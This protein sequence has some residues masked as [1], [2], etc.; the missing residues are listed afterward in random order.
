MGRSG[1]RRTHLPSSASRRADTIVTAP[2]RRVP[3]QML[4]HLTTF[5]AVAE[6][7]NF[8]QAARALARSQPAVTAQI[9]QLE[10]ELGTKLFH[11]STRN[12]RLTP[13]G[14]T[15]LVRARKLLADAAGVVDEVRAEQG[16]GGRRIAVSFSPT[17]AVSLV[18]DILA[19]VSCEMPRLRLLLREDLGAEMFAAVQTGAVDFGIG[20]Y[21][22]VP[23]GLDFRPILEQEL[24]LIFKDTHPIARNAAPRVRDLEALDILCS[25]RGSSAR[26]VL[27]RAAMA[28]GFVVRPRY[29][30]LQYPTLFS[31]AS[32]G[33]GV[34]VMPKVDSRILEALSL[35][36]RPLSDRR[37]RRTIGVISR[38]EERLS[39]DADA[40]I[41]TLLR[42]AGE[43]GLTNGLTRWQAPPH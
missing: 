22:R 26:D 19:R 17:L 34:T 11:R 7:L 38:R 10:G 8:R 33:L 24:Y 20:P 36:A 15:L 9:H 42:L 28:E 3:P 29:E 5:V 39:P 21:I 43:E 14:E 4:G 37:L 35:V 23:S 18:P 30:A 32:A 12:V 16:G 41:D 1:D 2:V 31:L 13:Q 27:D 40:I 25:A 6:L